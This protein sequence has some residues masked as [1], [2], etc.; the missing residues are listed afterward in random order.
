MA[1]HYEKLV[2]QY[3][4]VQKLNLFTAQSS[5]DTPGLLSTFLRSFLFY[6][7]H[8]HYWN[9]IFLWKIYNYS[10]TQIKIL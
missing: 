8:D 2:C 1:R 7:L 9:Q 6:L 3:L 5:T 10:E 4:Q